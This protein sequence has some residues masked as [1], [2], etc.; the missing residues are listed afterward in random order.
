MLLPEVMAVLLPKKNVSLGLIKIVFPHYKKAHFCTVLFETAAHYQFFGGR[1]DPHE[2]ERLM[3]HVVGK[4]ESRFED[5]I[6]VSFCRCLAEKLGYGPANA[7]NKIRQY[8]RVV[9]NN[10]TQY[11]GGMDC[12]GYSP[13]NDHD[14]EYTFYIFLPVFKGYSFEELILELNRIPTIRW[15]DSD[16]LVTNKDVMGNTIMKPFIYRDKTISPEKIPL[17]EAVEFFLRKQGLSLADIP[18]CT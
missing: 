14:R 16:V 12:T 15:Y 9:S 10:R 6:R 18:C 5:L 8:Y 3:Q 2:D 4:A 13:T 1:M 11:F 7:P 17:S